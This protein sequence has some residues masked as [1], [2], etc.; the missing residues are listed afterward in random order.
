MKISV[1]FYELEGAH[2][3]NAVSSVLKREGALLKVDL[4]SGRT[5]YADCFAW[6]ELGDLPLQQQ[7]DQLA[8]GE[9]TPITRCALEFGQIDARFRFEG[10]GILNQSNPPRSHF[11]ITDLFN[12]SVQD[13]QKLI[14]Q[15]YSHV[16]LKVGRRIEQE[17]ERLHEL[18]SN[19]PLKLRLDFNETP[20]RDRFAHFLQLIESLKERIDF[21]EDPFPFHPGEW[22]AFQEKGWTLACDR[23][24]PLAYGKAESARVLI[25]KQAV[26]PFNE[27]PKDNNQICIATSYL[28]H[29]IGQMAAGYAAMQLDPAGDF[30][31]G[32][33]SH[34]SYQ[35]TAFSRQLNWGGPNSRFHRAQDAGSIGICRI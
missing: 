23:Q 7:L 19:T 13:V 29:P 3:L 9:L 8:T 20:S 4:P 22:R 24:A 11:L 16:K 2:S 6:P 18:F 14:Q 26:I 12:C 5:G 10:G 34:H 30:V 27:F 15:G 35:P 32:L 33:L 17:A 21:I 31:H 28:G 1:S 25:I